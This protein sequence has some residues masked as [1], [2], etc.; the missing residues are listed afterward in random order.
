MTTK[1]TTK[2]E[3]MMSNT[4]EK[5]LWG[6][7]TGLRD[8]V[9]GE[10]I[11]SRFDFDERYNNGASLL[12]N[13]VVADEA[14]GDEF[15]VSI[16]VGHG[17]DKAD[18]EGKICEYPKEPKK[19]FNERSYYGMMINCAIM[20]QTQTHSNGVKGLGL[21]GVLRKKGNP[22]DATVWEGLRL[23]FEAVEF[24]FG[25]DKKAVDETGNPVKG[26]RIKSSRLF[27]VAWLGE[28][29]G[30]GGE[31]KPSSNGATATKAADEPSSSDLAP[32]HLSIL[33]KAKA[34]AKGDFDKFEDAVLN[35]DMVELDNVTEVIAVYWKG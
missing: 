23:R 4:I 29:S 18:R 26:A 15:T 22:M 30:G 9:A 6:T 21:A 19:R 2:Q 35:S 31:A 14:E 1:K 13:L 27:P 5:D 34:K 16:P 17:W 10:V 32:E 12:L 28:G 11:S 25:P 8:V 24:D 33:K 20:D 3:T 7:E